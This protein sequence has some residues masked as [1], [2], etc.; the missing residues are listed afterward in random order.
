MF[1]YFLMI[2]R[3]LKA[4]LNSFLTSSIDSA[5]ISPT[6]SAKKIAAQTDV[7]KLQ[8]F[9]LNDGQNVSHNVFHLSCHKI[10]SAKVFR[11]LR[12]TTD[13]KFSLDQQFEKAEDLS[14]AGK[15]IFKNFLAHNPEFRVRLHERYVPPLLNC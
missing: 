1:S 3:L 10:P 5:W 12:L 14:P 6:V 4:F 8:V 15:I 11:D 9:T 2:Y 13:R 7:N